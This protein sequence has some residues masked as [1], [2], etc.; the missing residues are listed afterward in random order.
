MKNIVVE[1]AHRGHRVLVL[2]EPTADQPVRYRVRTI[3]H[4][5]IDLRYGAFDSVDGALRSVGV[6][7]ATISEALSAVS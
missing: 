3:G 6:P 2:N 1:V 5:V 7:E 4:D